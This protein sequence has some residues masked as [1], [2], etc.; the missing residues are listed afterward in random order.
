MKTS[1]VKEKQSVTLQVAARLTG[2]DQGKCATVVGPSF[3][4]Q[5]LPG[6]NTKVLMVLIIFSCTALS[7]NVDCQM[8]RCKTHGLP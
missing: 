8:P 7:P 2:A 4:S 3:L 1:E 6:T 5:G